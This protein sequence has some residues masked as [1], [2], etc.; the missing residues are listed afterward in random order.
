MWVVFGCDSVGADPLAC[1]A[2]SRRQ[3]GPW[4]SPAPLEAFDAP[5]RP[6]LTG[7]VR[8]GVHPTRAMVRNGDNERFRATSVRAAQYLCIRAVGVL[9]GVEPA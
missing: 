4:D 6:V 3:A 9:T 5:E 2:G 8:R 1:V 7:T